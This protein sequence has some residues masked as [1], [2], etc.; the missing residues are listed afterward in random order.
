MSN[1]TSPAIS[2]HD[3]ARYRIL[4]E[5]ASDSI[6]SVD[7][8]ST[9][10]FAN[11]ST[12]K[13]FG[14]SVEELLGN[15]LTILMPE[16]LR[17]LHNAGMAK[18]VE[19]GEKH[20]SWEAVELPGL[21]KNGK[22]ISL[23][24]SFGKFVE[25][26]NHIFTGIIRDITERKHAEEQ[27]RRAFEKEK[28]LSEMKTMF[29]TTASHEFRTPISA[30]VSSAEILEHYGYKITD[31]KKAL[32]LQRIQDSAKNIVNLLE[33]IL[34]FNK[35]EAG[36]LPFNPAEVSITALCENI[37][38]NVRLEFSSTHHISFKNNASN[39]TALADK[40]LLCSVLENLLFNAI[41]FSPVNGD[42]RLE[43]F[44]N[45]DKIT[46][47]VS[48]N[49]IGIP[50]EDI[51]QIFE[52]FSRGKNADNIQGSGL[53]LSIVRRSVELHDGSVE[54]ASTVGE[55]TTITVAIPHRKF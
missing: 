31:E 13:I 4:A 46:F 28:E 52:P 22:E 34:L 45:N 48:D 23:E 39:L 1:I 32:H 26:G 21:H 54:I 11:R 50:P 53:G 30:I 41:K 42:V 14:Y 38:D 7:Q 27:V 10:L 29:I 16:Y 35:A 33:D 44:Q 25:N 24:V 47:I 51:E 17:N 49:G 43:L 37:V 18:H 5:T 8:T 6:I 36:K 19:T 55:G 20:I 2:N 15:D 3:D 12:E 9:I 40:K